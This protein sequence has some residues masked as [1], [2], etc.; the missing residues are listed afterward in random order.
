[1][2]GSRL[3]IDSGHHQVKVYPE[4]LLPYLAAKRL[5]DLVK[6]PEHATRLLNNFKWSAPTGECGVYSA[7]LPLAGWLSTL[8]IHC[9]HELI[10]IDPQAVAFFGDLRNPDI[11]LNEA[12]IALEA[13]IERLA[14]GG[15]YLGR[16]LYRLTAENYWQ[17]G[18]DGIEPTLLAL[19]E[20]HGSDFHARDALL[21]I[22][23]HSKLDVL[24]EPVLRTHG[25]DY[26]KLIEQTI[27][28]LYVLSLGR[29]DDAKEL[30][31]E[32]ILARQLPELTVSRLLSGLGWRFLSAQSIAD[33]VARHFVAGQEGFHI[34]W[35]ITRV[36]VESASSHQLLTL[37]RAL[38]LRLVSKDKGKESGAGFYGPD[39]NFVE[40][41]AELLAV[42]VKREDG[43]AGRIAKF[44]L[45]LNRF[46][47]KNHYFNADSRPLHSALEKNTV[48]RRHLLRGLIRNTDRTPRA[49]HQ[50]VFISCRF[51]PVVSGDEQ[52]LDEPGFTQLLEE[53][54]TWTSS[55]PRRSPSNRE[56]EQVLDQDAKEQ[57]QAVIEGI[58]DGSEK[59]ALAWIGSWLS[60]TTQLHRYGKCNF[61]LFER[62]AGE[63]L[64]D[65]VRS[66]LSILWRSQDPTWDEAQPNSTHL[67]TIAGLQGLYL[68]LGD[69][70]T[71]P[72]ITEEE[73]RRAIRYALFEING[74]PEWFWPVVREHT[75]VALNEFDG[76]INN[77]CLGPVSAAKAETLV[78]QLND[79]PDAIKRGMARTVWDFILRSPQVLEYTADAALKVAACDVDVIERETFE[80]EAQSRMLAAYGEKLPVLENA[81]PNF[82]EMAAKASVA[83]EVR[84]HEIRQQ[85]SNALVWGAFWL[86]KFPATFG[87]AW[88][89][90]QITNRLAAEEFMFDLAARLSE[91]HK[92]QLN[93][94]AVSGHEG[95]KALMMLYGWVSTV[96]REE[97]DLH[98][99][100]GKVYTLNVRDHAQ[101][102]RDALIPAIAHA[103]S[104]EAYA[105]LEA[106]RLKAPEHRIKYLRNVQ[107]ALREKQAAR[108]PVQQKHYEKFE[109]DF[110]PPVSEHQSFAMTVYNDL[111]SI[112]SQIENG[113]F[114][115][116]RFFNGISFDHMK[117][118]TKGLALEEDFQMLLGSELNHVCASRY[119]VSLEPILPNSTRRDVLCQT[120]THRATIELKMSER[121]TLL[122]YLEALEEQLVR[123]YMQAQNSKIGFF[124]VVLQRANREW[125]TPTGKR[126]RF[127]GLLDILSQ[128]ARELSVNDPTLYLRVIGIDASPKDNFRVAKKTAKSKRKKSS[129]CF[130]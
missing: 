94:L 40:L 88:E 33:V 84:S 115:L 93:Q 100:D 82:D 111:I 24:R 86:S 53:M 90:W 28:L 17:A 30:S 19:F 47:D 62:V 112:K 11:T 67:I 31:R 120:A 50:A 4:E 98:H 8:S 49:I 96:V 27:D 59:R 35:A 45:V 16:Q 97:E 20:K 106:L 80:A 130:S 118:G 32:L 64:S 85:R 77:A 2:L 76:I 38:L 61:S 102:L 15:D 89:S 124:V 7:Y 114:S 75:S 55:A 87:S 63:Q 42:A 109:T 104:E 57:L 92:S 81:L 127:E 125:V 34:S 74:F 66:G 1:L 39:R 121:W 29:E 126:V 41:L 58:R 103:K 3:F 107:F 60:R 14:N 72:K 122:E 6:S 18:K 65:A 129:S 56:T 52:A 54:K 123:Q 5:T 26:S 128:K 36:L 48:V 95:L 71:L 105:I 21:D 113:E 46:I 108:E 68:N 79:A 119:T 23:T 25:G 83:L 110:A 44:C 37:T 12:K 9:R 43:S 73:T 117:T 70:S 101:S 51:C 78:R 69:G 22:A 99:E 10:N 13:A 91:D 116:R